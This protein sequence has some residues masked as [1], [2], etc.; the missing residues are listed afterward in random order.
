M[1]VGLVQFLRLLAGDSHRDREPGSPKCDD[2]PSFHRRIGIAHGYDDTA[3]AGANDLRHTGGS[4][5]LEMATRFKRDVER[6]T[7][8][9]ESRAPQREKFC[10]RTTWALVKALPDDPAPIDHQGTDHRI[11]A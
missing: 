6:G 2:S 4:S 7:T 8:S 10:M 3:D 11:R 5:F 9:A 1:T